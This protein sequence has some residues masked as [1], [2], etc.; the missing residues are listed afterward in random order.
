MQI[1]MA[2][3]GIPP[4]L[5]VVTQLGPVVAEAANLEAVLDALRQAS[6]QYAQANWV[7]W[8]QALQSYEKWTA[9]GTAAVLGPVTQS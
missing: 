5:Q 9:R 1:A 3:D 2:V 4:D 6:S 7:I 8:V